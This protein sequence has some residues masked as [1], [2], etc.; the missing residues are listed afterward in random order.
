MYVFMYVRMHACIYSCFN[1]CIHTCIYEYMHACMKG[2][3]YLCIRVP[4]IYIAPFKNDHRGAVALAQEDP[5]HSMFRVQL[6]ETR[7]P[8][9]TH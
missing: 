2:S 1:V 8:K 6:R 4:K 9:C 7:C 3:M 5:A